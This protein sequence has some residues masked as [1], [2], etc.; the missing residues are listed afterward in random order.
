[1]IP[2]MVVIVRPA[3]FESGF[4]IVYSERKDDD[5]NHIINLIYS[6]RSPEEIH[7]APGKA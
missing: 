6:L 4:L 5:S 2:I 7:T 3:R 1:M